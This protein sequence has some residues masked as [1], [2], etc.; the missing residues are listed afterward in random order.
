MR[1]TIFAKA[2][3]CETPKDGDPCG[4]CENCKRAAGSFD[5]SEIDAA[6]NNGVD[7]IRELREEVLYPPTELKRRSGDA[8]RARRS[9]TV[10]PR[11]VRPQQKRVRPD[12]VDDLFEVGSGHDDY[13]DFFEDEVFNVSNL[14]E[15]QEEKRSRKRRR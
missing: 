15:K 3:S 10:P 12:D 8:P 11:Q 5:I 4:E 9:A 2:V 1:I 13:S 14:P 6:S 7:N